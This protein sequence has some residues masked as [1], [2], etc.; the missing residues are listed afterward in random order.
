M[1]ESFLK[2]FTDIIFLEDEPQRAD[3]IFIPGNGWPQM[4]QRA[5]ELW[6]EGMAPW[7]L[8]SGRYSV[9]KGRFGGVTAE[10]ERY[11]GP[12]A[13]EWEFLRDVLVK[14]GIPESAILREDSATYTYENAIYS[15]KVTDQVGIS[16]H[17]GIICCQS[18]HARRCRMYYQLLYPETEFLVVPSDTEVVRETW[19]RSERGIQLVLG[20]IER[21]GGQFHQILR[22]KFL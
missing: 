9:I 4:A 3:V 8:P 10:Q 12:Y 18:H 6:K 2:N 7:L 16:V 22:E 5:A 17:R 15:R 11:P 13:T 14:E 20:E 19:Y 21:C 1:H